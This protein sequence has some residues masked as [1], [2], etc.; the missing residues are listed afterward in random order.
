MLLVV[1]LLRELLRSLL[2]CASFTAFRQELDDA[3][4]IELHLS[5]FRT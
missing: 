5:S 3:F 4:L 1:N 2:R